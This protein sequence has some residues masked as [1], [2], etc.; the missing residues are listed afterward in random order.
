MGTKTDVKL[1]L[2]DLAGGKLKDYLEEFMKREN[3]SDNTRTIVL[4]MFDNTK[5]YFSWCASNKKD[6]FKPE[7]FRSFLIDKGLLTGKLI[8]DLS[9]Q[10]LILDGVALLKF[11]KALVDHSK[12]SEKG[13]YGIAF[14]FGLYIND[15]GDFLNDFTPAQLW[16]YNHF[17]KQSNVPETFPSPSPGPRPQLLGSRY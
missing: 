2:S 8:G 13:L 6:P 16:Y 12:Y 15:L 17:L 10:E 3:V 1:D 14:T 9:K 11:V 5:L 7:A 4:Y